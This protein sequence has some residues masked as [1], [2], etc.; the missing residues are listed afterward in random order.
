MRWL[1][2]LM[3]L[4]ALC[5]W[6]VASAA[7]ATVLE[8]LSFEQLIAQSALIVRGEVVA[9]R[10][11]FD[12]ELTHTVITLVVT[13]AL[14]GEAA[15]ALELA[16]VGGEHDGHVVSVSGQFIPA[17]AARGVFFI[18]STDVKM[19]NPLTGWHQGY[20]PVFT[21]D[22]GDDYLDMRQRLD[23]NIPGLDSNPIVAKMQG[24]GFS[25]SAIERKVPE[26]GLFT[27]DDFRAAIAAAVADTEVAP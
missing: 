20:F 17:V 19:V 27:W 8:S 23:F 3:R 7:Q 6:L 2:T 10:Q 13:E 18:A 16:F 5:A 14:K 25:P 24:L 4:V 11:E 26:V 22:L 9:S 1:T 15:G 12:G 21:D